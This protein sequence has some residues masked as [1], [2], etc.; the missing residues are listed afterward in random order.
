MTGGSGE[1]TATDSHRADDRGVTN[2]LDRLPWW[3]VA[4]L[5]LATSV[6][7][8]VL[9][10]RPFTSLS[11]LVVIVAV[12]LFLT[13]ATTLAGARLAAPRW[14]VV[15]AGAAWIVAGIVVVAWPDIS[16]RTLAAVVGVAMIVGGVLDAVAGLRGSTDERLAAVIGG[17]ASV[18]FGV[19][20]LTWPSVTVLVV[21]VVFG[22][23]LVV[24]GLRLAWS[25]VRERDGPDAGHEAP[26]SPGRL[27]RLGHVAGATVSLLVALALAGLSSQLNADG[28]VV[29]AF[30][31]TPDE[32][33]DEP[34]RLLRTDDFTRTIPD[35]ARAWRILYT[36]T[37]G[38][39][40]PAV[41]SAI[42][43]EPRAPADGPRPVIALANGTTGVQRPCAPS[44]LDDPF[45]AGAFYALD[46]VIDQGW[47]LVATDY[48]G[49]GS[50]GDHAYLVGEPAGRN[51]L[52]AVR[53]ARELESLELADETVVWGHSQGG[54]AALWTG[55]LASS[56]APDV[57]VIGVA[58]LAPA[59]DLV[60]LLDGLGQ[61]PAGAI[62]ASY[63]LDG[64][65]GYYDDVRV[66]DYVRPGARTTFEEI[67]DR[68]L[69]DPATLLSI[70]GSITLGDQIFA[71][72]LAGGPLLERLQENVPS[73]PIDAPLLLAQ[74][75][76]DSLVLRE[77]QDGYVAARCDDGQPI[78]YR[79]YPGLDHVPLVE[80][81][82]PLLPELVDWTI[83]R[84][85]GRPATPTCPG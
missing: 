34:G 21:A 44:V 43:V 1:P 16:T 66:A 6:L 17:V 67:A 48:V 42:V 32:V 77:V 61:N 65:A 74:G 31:D 38:D 24:F 9:V 5:G 35:D 57:G 19:L 73:G 3:V 52:D 68:C 60:G 51:V 80:A 7:G 23:R 70:V 85:A 72:E 83:D 41:A 79:T 28:P 56:Y 4:A 40:R 30:Y 82:S 76:E 63:V 64:F 69:T 45:G 84:F 26:T 50:E 20:A 46:G 15:V 27:R 55:V 62:F 53:A 2:P 33:P 36:T 81:D 12:G 22:A 59:S 14:P 71:R 58:A 13:G 18:V 10:F 39:G 11:V 75:E 54:G 8:A 25:A 37:I 47:A 49:L 78:D 29:D